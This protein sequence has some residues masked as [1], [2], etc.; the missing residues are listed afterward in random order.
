MVKG[1]RVIRQLGLNVA[2][3]GDCDGKVYAGLILGGVG[4]CN[5][6]QEWFDVGGV[7]RWVEC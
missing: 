3:D 4:M 6:P 1:M 7:K 2:H 5:T